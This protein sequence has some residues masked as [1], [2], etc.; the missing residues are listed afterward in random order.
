MN[1]RTW[2]SLS[3]AILASGCLGLAG[4]PKKK[5]AWIRL[6]NDRSEARD[7]ELS[8]ERKDEVVFREEFQLGT[9]PETAVARV[10]RPV[11]EQ[12]RYT[13]HFDLGEDLVHLPPSEFADAEITERCLGIQFTLHERGTSGFEFEPI[14][15]C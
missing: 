15:E 3:A 12:G 5:I 8:I 6:E 4:P 2:I 1:R 11:E 9:T 13:L 10:E 7:V 14:Q